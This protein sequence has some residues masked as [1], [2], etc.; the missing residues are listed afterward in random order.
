MLKPWNAGEF[1]FR[2]FNIYFYFINWVISRKLLVYK[3][4]TE[5]GCFRHQCPWWVKVRGKREEGGGG[6]RKSIFRPVTTACQNEGIHWTTVCVTWPELDS[7]W[8]SSPQP[9]C[10]TLNLR[11]TYFVGFLRQ[12]KQLDGGGVSFVENYLNSI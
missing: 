9:P 4:D 11:F 3:P 12:N 6:G 7:D 5:N 2:G 10:S 1:E 8:L